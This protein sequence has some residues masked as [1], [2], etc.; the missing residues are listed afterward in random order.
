MSALDG[1]CWPMQ[2][3]SDGDHDDGGRGGDSEG[4]SWKLEADAEQNVV[5]TQKQKRP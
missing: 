1:T 4:G 3:G 5:K 2:I